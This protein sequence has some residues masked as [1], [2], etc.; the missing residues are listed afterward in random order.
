MRFFLSIFFF[1]LSFWASAQT[2]SSKD[3]CYKDV[4]SPAC[5][6]K[7][8]SSIFFLHTMNGPR[9]E[10][11]N[12]YLVKF[13][14]SKGEEGL[15]GSASE[16]R[17]DQTM[18][19]YFLMNSWDEIYNKK[20]INDFPK[21]QLVNEKTIY[22]LVVR[23]SGMHNVHGEGIH[24]LNQLKTLFPE[25]DEGIKTTFEK[26]GF[27]WGVNGFP[28]SVIEKLNSHLHSLEFMNYK[29]DNDYLIAEVK[30]LIAQVTRIKNSYED[31]CNCKNYAEYEKLKT[32]FGD[33][34]NYDVKDKG[35]IIECALGKGNNQ[36]VSELIDHGEYNKSKLPS[37]LYAA[38]YKPESKE[39]FDLTQK[40]YQAMIAENSTFFSTLGNR[41]DHNLQML[42]SYGLLL[43]K[44]PEWSSEAFCVE[45]KPGKSNLENLVSQMDSILFQKG[46]S[47]VEQMMKELD[48]FKLDNLLTEFKDLYMS[49]VQF[50]RV[51]PRTGKTI[52]HLLCEEGRGDLI[53]KLD[54]ISLGPIYLGAVEV[55]TEGKYPIEVAAERR[56]R[57]GLEA[58]SY[59]FD[60][61]KLLYGYGVYKN[62]MKNV[63][64]TK[65]PAADKLI[66]YNL[67]NNLKIEMYE[68]Y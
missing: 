32:V 62:V 66:K 25:G 68:S 19:E 36:L 58:T 47:L 64:K 30:K 40:I 28:D 60:N 10:E 42:G 13:F 2:L 17:K 39:N 46:Y 18:F 63:R 15:F 37:Y 12:S 8:R 48:P 41:K 49:G 53:I 4:N 54:T 27:P 34:L 38:M 9:K 14:N 22:D 5:I 29:G 6:D 43:E 57:K 26:F 67:K 16:Y 55:N 24:Y 52:L 20:I 21:G 1:T 7:L 44:H 56:D 45:Y 31:A 3:P 61:T 35:D 51:N 65:L 50:N 23:D 59:L 33:I 11:H